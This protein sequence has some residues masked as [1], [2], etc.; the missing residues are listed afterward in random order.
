MTEDED[1]GKKAQR[2]GRVPLGS[3]PDQSGRANRGE[4]RLGEAELRK[5]EECCPKNDRPV[6]PVHD[7]ILLSMTG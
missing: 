7:F 5:R 2:G 4:L 6:Q 3:E 1:R